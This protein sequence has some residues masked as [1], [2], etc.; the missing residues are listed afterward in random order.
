MIGLTPATG[1][2]TP[3]FLRS[4]V[5]RA[6]AGVGLINGDSN[7]VVSNFR[8]LMLTGVKQVDHPRARGVIV[9]F[10]ATVARAA[11]REGLIAQFRKGFLIEPLTS[12]RRTQR[13]AAETSPRIWARSIHQMRR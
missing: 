3:A 2:R 1:S 8:I 12:F 13:T 6:N 9:S 10:P 4:G 11:I 5:V 7:A